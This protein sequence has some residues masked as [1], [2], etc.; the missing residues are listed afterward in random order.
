MTVATNAVHDIMQAR[1]TVR[2]FEEG[3]SIPQE[4]VAEILQNAVTA[5]SASNLQPWRFLVIQDQE[6]KKEL[7]SISYNQEQV[8]TSSAIIAILGDVMMYNKAHE[9]YTQSV[10]E[11]VMPQKVADYMIEAA[12]HQAHVPVEERKQA[13]SFDCGLV[14]MQIMLLAKERGLETGPMAGFEKDKFA[15]RFK[16]S[17]N[18]VPLV[19]ITLGYASEPAHGSSRL[20]AKELTRY[21]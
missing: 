15:E 3:K 12:G 13:V 9:I 20:D 14:A 4:V 2:K 11:G 10:T 8:E 17:E 18:L 5:P 19:F 6:V 7:R 1:K 16:L 21:I